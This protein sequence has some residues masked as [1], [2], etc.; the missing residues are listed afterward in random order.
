MDVAEQIKTG[1]PQTVEELEAAGPHEVSKLWLLARSYSRLR[2]KTASRKIRQHLDEL[3]AH[4]LRLALAREP[5]LFL[6]FV[7]PGMPRLRLVYH[8]EERNLLHV[9]V[10]TDLWD[11]ATR[12][13]L[14]PERLF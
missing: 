4:C 3:K 2:H 7:D 10:T 12:G 9:P 13:D 14:T 1:L 6:V 11:S 5:E 8:R